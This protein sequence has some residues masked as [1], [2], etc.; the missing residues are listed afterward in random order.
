MAARARGNLQRHIVLTETEARTLRAIAESGASNSQL[1][2]L[3]QVSEAAIASRL[4]RL[5]A[6]VGFCT[7]T[8]AAV[9]AN[10]HQECCIAA[11]SAKV[12]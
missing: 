12:Q 3:F 2:G 10:M 4:H 7:R 11:C 8:E 6:R 5:F 9:W 1:A